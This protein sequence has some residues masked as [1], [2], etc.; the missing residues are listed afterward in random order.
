MLRHGDLSTKDEP[1]EITDRDMLSFPWT[2]E[3]SDA[4]AILRIKPEQELEINIDINNIEIRKSL[5]GSAQI[6]AYADINIKSGRV[7]IPLLNEGSAT[8]ADIDNDGDQDLLLSGVSRETGMLSTRLLNNPLIG[9]G[10][11]FSDITISL[12][13]LKRGSTCLLYTSPSPRDS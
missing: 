10:D 1:F 6:P 13:G 12:P 5:V 3:L 8:W 4:N 9:G 2:R 7:N 11:N